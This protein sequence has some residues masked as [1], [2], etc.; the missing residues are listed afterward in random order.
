[1]SRDERSY[2]GYR[3]TESRTRDK[4]EKKFGLASKARLKEL[5]GG[6]SSQFKKH[7]L[8]KKAKIC[9]VSLVVS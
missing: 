3:H 6:K 2:Y 8:T 9:E 1:M 5:I 4:V 7:R